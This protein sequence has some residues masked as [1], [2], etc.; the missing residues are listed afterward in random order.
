MTWS[1]CAVDGLLGGLKE[2]KSK[3]IK[4]DVQQGVPVLFF[5]WTE[6]KKCRSVWWS[7][8]GWPVLA[9]TLILAFCGTRFEQFRVT[10]PSLNLASFSDLSLFSVLAVLERWNWKLCFS[11]SFIPFY[12]TVYHWYMVYLDK[13]M[14]DASNWQGASASQTQ[15]GVLFYL[16]C[17]SAEHLLFLFW[18]PVV[19]GWRSN[20]S[21]CSQEL[22]ILCFESD[23]F[24]VWVGIGQ[25]LFFHHPPIPS[26]H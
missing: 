20:W 16:D 5:L 3:M 4:C 24:T 19:L 8:F 12:E 23:G 26:L 10:I 11:Y 17:K 2:T 14:S 6:L 9:K 22:I 7:L 1:Y 25:G 13:I 15:K 21:E 18:T